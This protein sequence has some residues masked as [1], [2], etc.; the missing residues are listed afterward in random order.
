MDWSSSAMVKRYRHVTAPTRKDVA[1]RL[2]GPGCRSRPER[3][4]ETPGMQMGRLLTRPYLSNDSK[5]SRSH[6]KGLR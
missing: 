5:T 1:N 4:V 3:A 6:G 2:G